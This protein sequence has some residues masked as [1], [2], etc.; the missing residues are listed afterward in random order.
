MAH[1]PLYPA[2]SD[3]RGIDTFQSSIPAPSRS[4]IDIDAIS[5]LLGCPD[6]VVPIF[7]HLREAEVNAGSI[8]S[9]FL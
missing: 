5:S 4:W 9:R 7:E 6:Y 8:C 2:A 3:R 1:V